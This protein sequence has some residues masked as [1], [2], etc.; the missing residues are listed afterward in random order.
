MF[1]VQDVEYTADQKD[2]YDIESDFGPVVWISTNK[3]GAGWE[4][5]VR[6]RT[7]AHVAN[8]ILYKRNSTSI[9]VIG[10]RVRV[11]GHLQ[12]LEIN[13]KHGVFEHKTPYPFDDHYVY[14]ISSIMLIRSRRSRHGLGI[15]VIHY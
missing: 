9:D 10:V 14:I 15:V 7:N 6:R 13:G 4:S 3:T 8:S 12:F 5:C 11:R 2:I 1:L